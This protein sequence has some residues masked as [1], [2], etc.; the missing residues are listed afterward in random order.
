MTAHRWEAGWR[1]R[2]QGRERGLGGKGQFEAKGGSLAFLFFII[3]N[4]G[5]FL[6]QVIFKMYGSGPR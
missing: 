5:F 4:S 1:G 3:I 2:G 6:A